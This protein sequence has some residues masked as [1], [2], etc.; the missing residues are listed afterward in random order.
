[1]GKVVYLMN[2]SLDGYVETA[3]HSVDWG[4]VD[5]ELHTWFSDRQ[6]E[7]DVSVYGRRLWEVMAAY[8][9]TGEADPRS[10]EPMREFARVWNATP[11]VVFSHELVSVEHGG[12]SAATLARSWRSCSASSTAR[13]TWVDR[14][15]RR[16]S[17]STVS[18]T[19][20]G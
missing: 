1:M 17:S 14:R 11:K 18:S 7:A 10:T 2:V 4:K 9:P 20:I 5:D 6:R 19:S 8:W 16:S 15:S 13:S 3:D 12:L